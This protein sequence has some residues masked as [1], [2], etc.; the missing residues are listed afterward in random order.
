M[1]MQR[2][3]N[4][5]LSFSTLNETLAPTLQNSEYEGLLAKD[6]LY[7]K[8]Y[9]SVYTYEILKKGM[10]YVAFLYTLPKGI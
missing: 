6:I 5:F 2:I 9:E 1:K 4:P 7:E 3:I 10:P 8:V